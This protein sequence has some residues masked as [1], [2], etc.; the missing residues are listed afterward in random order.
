ME[1]FLEIVAWACVGFMVVALLYMLRPEPESKKNK[2]HEATRDA[3]NKLGGLIGYSDI[4]YFDY[5][6]EALVHKTYSE[7]KCR[8]IEESRQA[9]EIKALRSELDMLYNHLDLKITKSKRQVTP[10]WNIGTTDWTAPEGFGEM[11]TKKK[12]K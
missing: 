8:S 11:K 12:K 9:N 6:G 4:T 1:T 10:I 3:L 7:V 2:K 5:T